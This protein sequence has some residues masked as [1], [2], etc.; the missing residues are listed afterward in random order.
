M[1][2]LYINYVNR[3]FLDP[4]TPLPCNMHHIGTISLDP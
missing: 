1:G 2:R 3:D 4:P